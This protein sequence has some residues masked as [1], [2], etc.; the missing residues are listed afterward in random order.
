MLTS[1][2]EKVDNMQEKMSN[3]SRELETLRKNKKKNV[4]N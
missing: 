2:R 4:I 1:L 3:L